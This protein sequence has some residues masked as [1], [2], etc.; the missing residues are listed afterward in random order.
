M[1]IRTQAKGL[2]NTDRVAYFYYEDGH[3]FALLNLNEDEGPI[4]VYGPSS[5]E[6]CEDVF[7]AICSHLLTGQKLLNIENLS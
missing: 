6:D 7:K 5:Y 4:C 3:V 2:L 1:W